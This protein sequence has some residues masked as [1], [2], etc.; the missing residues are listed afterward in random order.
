MSNNAVFDFIQKIYDAMTAGMA[1]LVAKDYPLL[2]AKVMPIALVAAMIWV[3]VKVIR[4]HSGRDPADIWPLLRMV[5][6]I[7]VVFSGLNWGG[8]GGKVFY[9]FSEL[10]DDTVRAFMGGKTTLQYVQTVCGK[11]GVLADSMMNQSAWNLGI[12]LLG[13]IL[14]LLD[15]LLA[16][17]VLVLN[18]A[19]V[20]GLG[21][22]AVLG[23]LFFPLLFWSA[24]RGYAMNWFSAMFKFALVGILLGVTVVFSF[25]VAVNLM[26]ST[27][28][29]SFAQHTADAMAAIV[30]VGFLILFVWLGVKPL[31]SALASSGAAAGGVAEMAAGFAVSQMLQKFLAPVKPDPPKPDPPPAPANGPGGSPN[32]S[33]NSGAMEAMQ[34]APSGAGQPGEGSRW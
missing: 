21:I 12:V 26:D 20:M 33:T 6:T 18:V 14:T 29:P 15:C 2:A 31:A 4:V 5:L 19:S 10:R 32:S 3:A 30:M 1:T 11:V 34:H 23:P 9:A 25:Q 17:A 16:L 8:L 27:V 7:L 22:T 24:T 28:V 13:V